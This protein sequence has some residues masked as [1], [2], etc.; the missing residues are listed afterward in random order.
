MEE[1]S[2]LKSILADKERE[3]EY[4]VGKLKEERVELKVLDETNQNLGKKQLQE[5]STQEKQTL[6]QMPRGSLSEGVDRVY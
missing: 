1:R 5:K 6:S 4:V 3:L 2:R